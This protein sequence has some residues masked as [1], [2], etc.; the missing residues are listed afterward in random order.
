MVAVKRGV[1]CAIR[2]EALRDTFYGECSDED[3]EYA[4]AR[5]AP[6]ALRVL[7]AP[8]RVTAERFGRVPRAYVHTLRDHAVSPAAQ[9]R[10][11]SAWPCD[12]V[13]TL[14]TDHSPFLSQ[15]EALARILISI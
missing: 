11:Q 4:R 5:L 12:P 13:F 10:M 6:E 9:R 15:P 7:A 1:T 3:F 8:V 14:D 2:D